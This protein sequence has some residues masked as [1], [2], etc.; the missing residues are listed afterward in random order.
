MIVFADRLKLLR[1]FNHEVSSMTRT[2]ALAMLGDEMFDRL[3]DRPLADPENERS[4]TID[5]LHES[6]SRDGEV[7]ALMG[8]K[9]SQ[10]YGFE[11]CEIFHTMPYALCPLRAVE[12]P[13]SLSFFNARWISTVSNLKH[14]SQ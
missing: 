4:V 10:D 3:A 13:A 11:I 9:E 6:L 8:F 5:F 12:K 2:D 1:G 14:S 7:L